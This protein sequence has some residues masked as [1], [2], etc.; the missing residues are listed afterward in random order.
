MPSS[1]TVPSPRVSVQVA[2]FDVSTEVAALRAQDAQIGA[3]VSFVGTVREWLPAVADAGACSPSLLE[4]E[5]YPGMTEA[6]I[7]AMIDE[8]TR[9]FDLRGVRVIHRI[10]RL[11]VGD[12]IV[13]VVTASG[14]RGQAFAGC[15]FLMDWLKTQAPFWKKEIS[16][17]GERWVEANARDD[18]ALTRWGPLPGGSPNA[19]T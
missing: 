1:A 16:A 7:E 6:A 13:L 8:A 9:R 12:Q 17:Q 11:P 15:E 4:L 2:D 5:H 10:G 19:R 3:L 14:H 18:Q